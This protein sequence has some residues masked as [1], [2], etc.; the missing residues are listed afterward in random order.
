MVK[1][2]RYGMSSMDMTA[3]TTSPWAPKAA[4]CWIF[5]VRVEGGPSPPTCASRRRKRTS[6]SCVP[7][8][9]PAAQGITDTS[10]S[11]CRRWKSARPNPHPSAKK[12]AKKPST[13]TSST[14]SASAVPR[15]VFATCR[16]SASAASRACSGVSTIELEAR[17]AAGLPP[18]TSGRP[19]L[20]PAR[21]TST[22]GR[23]GS[24]A[25]SR[26][27]SPSGDRGGVPPSRS[28]VTSLAFSGTARASLSKTSSR[29]AGPPS[30]K[31]APAGS[32]TARYVAWY[33]LSMLKQSS[34]SQ[35]L[36]KTYSLR[37]VMMAI[38]FGMNTAVYSFVMHVTCE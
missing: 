29:F 13:S 35:K 6:R 11:P 16:S 24:S 15:A 37:A 12:C 19:E 3:D 30:S 26:V 10:R 36:R 32:T 22:S 9:A 14:H 34:R 31:C 28:N 8:C 20:E 25:R 4:H 1:Q 33:A 2:S 38:A 23:R 27:T 21:A 18:P 17:A 7:G 5:V